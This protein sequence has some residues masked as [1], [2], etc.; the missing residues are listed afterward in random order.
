L[1]TGPI[2][3]WKSAKNAAELAGIRAAH[4]RDGVAMVRFLRWLEGAVP[5]G[6]VSELS[7][8]EVLAGFRKRGERYVGPSF[9]T[10]AGY[11]GH[12]AIVHYSATPESSARL[13]PEG[14]FLI[15]S[16]GQ[17][18][19]GTTDITRTVALGEPTT[20]QRR[21][22]TAVLR[23]HLRLRGARFAAGTNGYQLDVLARSP[24]WDFF[25]DYNHGTGHGVGASLCV[26]EGPF[27]VSLRKNLTPLQVGNVLSNEPGY[28]RAGE[29]GI[30]VENLVQVVK[31][32]E[33][34]HGIFLGFDDLT[35]CPYDRRLLDVAQL[36]E[37]ERAQI[38]AYHGRVLREL[39]PLL[40]P[41]ERG[42]LE[43]ACAPLEPS[44]CCT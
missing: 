32:A 42:W 26:H 28:Y 25:L 14:L 16:G 34:D 2:P 30:R 12:G 38:D 33:N 19:D 37:G 4:V 21:A 20:E 17:Y 39:S 27:S 13:L 23:G 24:L 8:E 36:N 41:D 22:Y 10:I 31:V 29:F 7:A 1:A 3:A 35:L 5:A 44:C 15:D 18:V 11:A 9:R 43:V 40:A 6:G